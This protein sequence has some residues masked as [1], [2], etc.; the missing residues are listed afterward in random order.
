[1]CI[2]HWLALD[3]PFSLPSPHMRVRALVKCYVIA[4]HVQWPEVHEELSTRA[5]PANPMVAHGATSVTIGKPLDWPTY[6]WDNEYGRRDVQ[7]LAPPLPVSPLLISPLLVSPHDCAL[8]I[9]R[10]TSYSG[11]VK[12]YLSSEFAHFSVQYGCAIAESLGQT[13]DK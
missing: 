13:P 5:A 3:L 12:A 2:E 10:V 9:S 1:M 7:V 4:C 6:G 11:I 8:G